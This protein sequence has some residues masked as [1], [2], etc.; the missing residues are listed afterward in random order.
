VVVLPFKLKF[1]EPLNLAWMLL[2]PCGAVTIELVSVRGAI[3]G[4]VFGYCFA[5]R[6]AV[7]SKLVSV[8]GAIGRLVFGYCFAMRGAVAGNFGLVSCVVGRLAFV[9]SFALRGAVGW[10]GVGPA[11]LRFHDSIS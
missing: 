9:Y 2:K 8:R 3:G 7:T 10:A 5:M 6:S 11:R 4:E 1:T